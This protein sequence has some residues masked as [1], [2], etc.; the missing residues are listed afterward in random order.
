MAVLNCCYPT[1]ELE[2]YNGTIDFTVDSWKEEEQ[3]SLREAAR[4]QA[5][6]NKFTAKECKC[7]TGCVTR[8]C[9]CLKNNLSCSSHCHGE[10]PCSNK[11]YDN[12]SLHHAEATDKGIS[13]HIAAK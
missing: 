12:Q 2:H 8:K 7:S 10:R 6:W 13:R 11:T 1:S 9:R 3:L 4:R 5:P